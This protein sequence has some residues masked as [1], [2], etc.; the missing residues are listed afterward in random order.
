MFLQRKRLAVTALNEKR[1]ES[2]KPLHFCFR[3]R[4]E[5][6]QYQ[7]IQRVSSYLSDSTLLWSE[8]PSIRV[9]ESSKQRSCSKEFSKRSLGHP[10]VEARCDRFPKRNS[11]ASAP[12]MNFGGYKN[13][14]G[15]AIGKD[16][17]LILHCENLR[18]FPT[19]KLFTA[20]CATSITWDA[21][22]AKDSESESK[23]PSSIP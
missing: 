1:R 15:L 2:W 4:L 16:V 5:A 22:T 10:L 14:L 19:L 23:P 12:P 17:H 7:K 18:S 13:A 8:E 11:K 3:I 20:A 6:R 21:T 9:Q